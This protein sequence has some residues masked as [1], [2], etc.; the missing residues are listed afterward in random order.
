[1]SMSHIFTLLSSLAVSSVFP[2]LK[3]STDRT[4]PECPLI[5]FVFV[6]VPGNHRRTELS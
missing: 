3:N 2:S 5:V 6:F 1:V 4:V